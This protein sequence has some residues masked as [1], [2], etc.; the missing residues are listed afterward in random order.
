MEQHKAIN[1]KEDGCFICG[2]HEMMERHHCFAGRANRKISEKYADCCCVWLCHK[3]H[4]QPPDGVHYDPHLRR[5]LQAYAQ[6]KFEEKYGHELFMLE[7]KKN[8]G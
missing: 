2:S 8:Y 6:Q 4:N 5:I 7:F 1:R 3:H